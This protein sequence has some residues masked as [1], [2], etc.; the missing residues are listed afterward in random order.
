MRAHCFIFCFVFSLFSLSVLTQAYSQTYILDG[1]NTSFAYG[2]ISDTNTIALG[3]SNE[4][5]FELR[6]DTT[7]WFIPSNSATGQQVCKIV[8]DMFTG[9]TLF[10]MGD[11]NTSELIRD[12]IGIYDN[13]LSSIKYK[14]GLTAAIIKPLSGSECSIESPGGN[15]YLYIKDIN[16]FDKKLIAFF[17]LHHYL[18]GKLQK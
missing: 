5:V 8:N 4:G 7:I 10:L 12:T 3:L 11:Y 17:V 14:T 16:A 6:G 9:A 1:K 2:R 13:G 18:A 15:K